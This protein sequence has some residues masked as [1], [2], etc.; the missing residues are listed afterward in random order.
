MHEPMAT[1]L[2]LLTNAAALFFLVPFVQDSWR[3]SR[4]NGKELMWVPR[5]IKSLTI[6]YWFTSGLL[7]VGVLSSVIPLVAPVDRSRIQQ[8]PRCHAL[9]SNMCIAGSGV[10][11]S[12]QSPS[13]A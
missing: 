2:L 1:I 12:W 11:R 8:P 13:E 4:Q 9:L 3:W 5:E 10:T 6:N 7:S